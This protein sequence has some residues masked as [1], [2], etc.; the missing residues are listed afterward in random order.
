MLPFGAGGVTEKLGRGR[1]GDEEGPTESSEVC[2][3]PAPLVRG[4]EAN[5]EGPAGLWMENGQKG[6]EERQNLITDNLS[7]PT[8]SLFCLQQF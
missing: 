7:A 8:S 2:D 1:G 4:L 3:F 5:G 6:E